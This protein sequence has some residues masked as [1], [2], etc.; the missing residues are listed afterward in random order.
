LTNDSDR[1]SSTSDTRSSD[2]SNNLGNSSNNKNK[3]NDQKTNDVGNTGENHGSG[4]TDRQGS[5]EVLE[6]CLASEQ[7]YLD[8]IA[9]HS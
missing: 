6:I 3:N 7:S 5:S 9:Q 2:S 1:G 4:E 8:D